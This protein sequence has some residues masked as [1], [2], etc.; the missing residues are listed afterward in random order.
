MNAIVTRNLRGD[1]RVS[2]TLQPHIR[3]ARG[4]ARRMKQTGQRRYR[5]GSRG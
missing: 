3:M 1:I 5:S 2:S 4:S